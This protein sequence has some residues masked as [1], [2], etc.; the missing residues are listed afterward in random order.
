MLRPLCR[1]ARGLSW[2]ALS[3]PA[4]SWRGLGLSSRGLGLSSRGFFFFVLLSLGAVSSVRAQEVDLLHAVAADVA[5]SSAYRGRASQLDALVDGDLETAWNSSSGDL[6]TS[7]IEVRLPPTSHVSSIA[8]TVGFTHVTERG[9]DLFPGNHRVRRVRVSHDAT[10]L[11]EHTLD[12]ASRALQS[13][14]VTGGGGVYRIE[15][16]GTEPGSRSDWREVCVS[17]LRVMGSDPGARAGQR[18]PRLGVGS[19]PAPRGT[20]A[21]D[22]AALGREHRQRVAAFEQ[23]W[24][25]LERIEDQGRSASAPSETWSEDVAVIARTRRAALLHLADYVAQVDEIEGDALRARARL[26]VPSEW[27]SGERAHVL[28]ADLRTVGLAMDVV[29]RFLDDDAVRCRWARALGGLHLFRAVSYASGDRMFAEMEESDADMEGHASEI[30]ATDHDALEDA[31]M[32]LEGALAQWSGNTRGV[33]PRLRRLQLP[34]R[35]RA[36]T[37]LSRLLEQLDVAQGTCGWQ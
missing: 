14:P 29:S 5:V 34:T 8:L 9:L 36:A 23:S 33:A 24:R 16:V 11:G 28:E 3:W 1:S 2:P 15:I 17:E 13:V 10:A 27:P 31:A 12:V 4:L 20:T 6:T 21:P 22:P 7:W 26:R 19:L 37:D 32:V 30:S 18:V 25:E 35:A